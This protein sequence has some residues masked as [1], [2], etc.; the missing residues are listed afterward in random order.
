VVLTGTT[1]PVNNAA[2]TQQVIAPNGSVV[3]TLSATT[4]STAYAIAKW[5]SRGAATGTYTVKITAVTDGFFWSGGTV[6]TTTFT[7]Q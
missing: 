4:T 1:T 2:V 3:A 6:T 5:R 7:L